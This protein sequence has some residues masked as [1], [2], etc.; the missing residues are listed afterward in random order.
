MSFGTWIRDRLLEAGSN[1]TT[2]ADLHRI[3]TQLGVGFIDEDTVYKGGTYNTFARYFHW[4]KQLGFVEEVRIEPSTTKGR[5][6][7]PEKEYR[8]RH[9][10][11]ISDKGRRA[12]IDEWRDPIATL[13]PEWTP[14]E[15]KRRYRPPTGRPRGRPRKSL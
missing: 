10:Y 4:L 2:V 11:R 8:P 5:D 15:R 9:Y 6:D 14:T 3:R 1:G 12:S 7:A 13:H